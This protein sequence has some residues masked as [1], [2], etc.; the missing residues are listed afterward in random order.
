MNNDEYV[1]SS[2]ENAPPSPRR[3][4]RLARQDARN[5]EDRT[6]ILNIAE[7]MGKVDMLPEILGNADFALE[8]QELLTISRMS[9]MEDEERLH[10]YEKT[11]QKIQKKLNFAEAKRAANLVKQQNNA[12]Q[13]VERTDR[14]RF[15]I[16]NTLKTKR[17]ANTALLSKTRSNNIPKNV[18]RILQQGRYAK[19]ENMQRAQNVVQSRNR[20]IADLESRLRGYNAIH[21]RINGKHLPYSNYEAIAKELE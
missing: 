15:R 16:Q 8:C 14:L 17:N 19:Q 3:N 21:S 7:L 12:F 5:M 9:R 4:A 20:Q 1:Y 13:E 10:A 2:N 11:F 18:R 6:A